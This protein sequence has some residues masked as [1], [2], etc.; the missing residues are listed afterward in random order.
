MKRQNSSRKTTRLWRVASR[1]SEPNYT[2]RPQHHP[3]CSVPSAESDL[4]TQAA[5]LRPRSDS[6][7]MVATP[8][9]CELSYSGG[10]GLPFS[11]PKLLS[12]SIAQMNCAPLH[13]VS[14]NSDPS[15]SLSA[16]SLSIYVCTYISKVQPESTAQSAA[17]CN[18]ALRVGQKKKKNAAL[19]ILAILIV[20]H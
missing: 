10:D 1:P 8:R 13:R 11:S 15:I 12:Q 17:R 19:S 9:S 6:H 18:C 3:V 16:L 14:T 2:I 20:Q 5:A 4:P 7:E